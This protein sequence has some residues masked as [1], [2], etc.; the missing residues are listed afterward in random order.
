M[1]VLMDNLDDFDLNVSVLDVA[2]SDASAISLTDDGCGSTCDSPCA[3]A[4]A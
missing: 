3:T 4:V 2:D 1:E